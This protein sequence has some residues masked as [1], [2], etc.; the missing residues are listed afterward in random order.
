ML[1]GVGGF[2]EDLVTEDLYLGFSLKM[3]GFNIEM[4]PLLESAESPEDIRS[5]I[6][7]KYVWFW[8]PLSYLR[9]WRHFN[10]RNPNKCKSIRDTIRGL[11]FVVQGIFSGI[12]WLLQGPILLT[13]VLQILLIPE[14]RIVGIVVLILYGPV[15]Y[16]FLLFRLPYIH[17][18]PSLLKCLSFKDRVSMLMLSI[19]M[20]IF[21]S[22]PPYATC[23]VEVQRIFWGR[24]ITK[25][26]TG[27]IGPK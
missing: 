22:I 12:A 6:W 20:A 13:I 7:Q 2:A 8:G 10:K 27:E 25:P 24:R 19:P 18:N 11:G 21:H 26:K 14:V 4:I 23:Y 15:Q 1:E 5:L 3:L 17:Y 16:G 9:Y